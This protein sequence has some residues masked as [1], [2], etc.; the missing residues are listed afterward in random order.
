MESILSI[1][2]SSLPAFLTGVLGPVVILVARHYL[3][4]HK[5]TKD[6]IKDAAENGEIICKIL[7]QILDDSSLDR[8]WITQFHNGGHFYPTGKSIQKFSMIYEAVS[9]NAESIRHNFQ[10]IPI[11]LFSKSIN[12]LLDHDRIIIV[13]YKDEEIPTYGLRYLAE[14]TNCKSSYMFALKNIDGKMIGVL[15][16]EATKRK[17]DLNDEVYDNIKTHAAQIGVLLD[18]FL[19]KK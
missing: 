1:V 5:K 14:E 11:N 13:D 15:S 19:R 9:A 12:R 16:A 7:D 10:N 18:A 17:K 6:P 8:V 3:Q 4:E 2:S